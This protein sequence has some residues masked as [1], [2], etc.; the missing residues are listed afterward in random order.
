M[1][2]WILK[3]ILTELNPLH[4][5]EDCR[6]Y[7]QLIPGHTTKI[8]IRIRS[9]ES[10]RRSQEGMG[11]GSFLGPPADGGGAIRSVS[12]PSYRAVPLSASY[13]IVCCFPVTH[14]AEYCRCESSMCCSVQ[15]VAA[16]SEGFQNRSISTGGRPETGLHSFS[17]WE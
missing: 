16:G 11:L 10:Q 15:A 13:Q 4:V 12:K 14:S 6:R 2:A 17:S 1:W 5:G 8:I 9:C 3:G 7:F